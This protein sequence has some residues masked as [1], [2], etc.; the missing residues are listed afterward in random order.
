MKVVKRW[1]KLVLVAIVVLFLGMW[2]YQLIAV[3]G[4]FA[5]SRPAS[6]ATGSALL[7]GAPDHRI[8]GR[9]YLT[10]TPAP[11]APLVVV[12]HGDAPFVNPRYQYAFSSDVAEAAPGT[13][14]AALL[15]PGYGD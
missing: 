2:G 9:V 1:W 12:L 13:R 7:V 8:A 5:P 15:R 14:V 11:S 3:R 6:E 10:G 4:T